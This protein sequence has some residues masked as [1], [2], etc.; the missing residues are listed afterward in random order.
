MYVKLLVFA[1]RMLRDFFFGVGIFL[2]LS[3][4]G[5]PLF[6]VETILVDESFLYI[7]FEAGGYE[8]FYLLFGGGSGI[9]VCILDCLIMIS[10]NV[11]EG[12]CRK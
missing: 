10:R 2:F 3:L 12:S 7:L 8:F 1:W 11:D 6:S 9:L 5:V 4:L